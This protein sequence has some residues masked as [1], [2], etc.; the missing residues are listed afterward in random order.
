MRDN[1]KYIK[2]NDLPTMEF[3]ILNFFVVKNGYATTAEMNE[4]FK[5]SGIPTGGP[6]FEDILQKGYLERGPRNGKFT[7]TITDAGRARWKRLKNEFEPE[8]DPIPVQNITNSGTL[9]YAPDNKGHITHLDHSS[10]HDLTH[11]ETTTPSKN[12][13]AAITIAWYSKPLFKYILWPLAVL[14]LFGIL[15]YAIGLYNKPPPTH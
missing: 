2:M 4:D 3:H 5:R 10:L 8:R 6:G 14:I 12:A 1:H 7:Y 9:I 15:T 13:S 11:T